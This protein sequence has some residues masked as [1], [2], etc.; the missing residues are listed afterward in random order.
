MSITDP[1]RTYAN[2]LQDAYD[3]FNEKLFGNKLPRALITFTRRKN[4]FGHF[5]TK[6]WA[7]DEN[8]IADEIAMNPEYFRVRPIEDVLS[9]LVHEMTHQEQYHFGNPSRSGYH[10]KE[11]GRL[12]REVGLIPSSTGEPG[13]KA[14]GQKVSHYIDEGGPFDVSVRELVDTGYEITWASPMRD[15]NEAKPANGYVRYV[16]LGCNTKVR[17]KR[18]LTIVCGDCDSPFEDC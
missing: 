8:T 7:A 1:T 2:Q 4:V 10:N 12:M 13:G 6:R 14:T 17:G 5:G 16:C 9:T 18:G 3:F 11:W 15:P